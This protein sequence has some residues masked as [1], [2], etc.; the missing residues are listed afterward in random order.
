M[1][2]SLWLA[3]PQAHDYP[4]ALDYLTLLTDAARAKKIVKSLRQAETVR[5]KAK[6]ILRASRLEPLGVDNAHVRHDLGKMHRGERLSPVL[7]VRGDATRDLP[8]VI[9]DGFHRVCAAHTLHEDAE[10]PCRIVDGFTGT[11]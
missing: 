2:D 6:D 5:K 9:A 1:H 11:V 4:A 3:E 7:L 10:V 8:L